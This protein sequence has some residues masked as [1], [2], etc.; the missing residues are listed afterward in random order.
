MYL[1][2]DHV[3]DAS[4]LSCSLNFGG[5]FLTIYGSFYGF[6]DSFSG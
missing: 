6:N 5:L 1:G 2:V 4:L 3:A